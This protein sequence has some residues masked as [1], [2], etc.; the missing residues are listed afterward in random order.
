VC[1]Y[2]VVSI[3]PDIVE[4]TVARLKHYQEQAREQGRAAGQVWGANDATPIELS[5]LAHYRQQSCYKTTDREKLAEAVRPSC[6]DNEEAIGRFWEA[7]LGED[8]LDRAD[9]PEFVHGFGTGAAEVWIAVQ[10][11]L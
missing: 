11:K 2:L 6:R 7:V 1:S 4:R 9:E 8:D 3:P 5:K 10:G